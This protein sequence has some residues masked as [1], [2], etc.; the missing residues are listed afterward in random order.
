M[1]KYTMYCLIHFSYDLLSSATGTPRLVSTSTPAT[2][3]ATEQSTLGNADVYVD[4]H[5]LCACI[6]VQCMYMHHIMYIF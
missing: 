2:S 6:H 5:W 4:V 1:C 3:S